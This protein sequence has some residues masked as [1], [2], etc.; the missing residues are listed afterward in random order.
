MMS[1]SALLAGFPITRLSLPGLG[2]LPTAKLQVGQFLSSIIVPMKICA[3]STRTFLLLD[4]Q[5]VF[6]QDTTPG[7][8]TSTGI[9]PTQTFSRHKQQQH[10]SGN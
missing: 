1:P 2:L 3:R 6:P 8:C 5:L 4:S 10:L 9:F 7:G